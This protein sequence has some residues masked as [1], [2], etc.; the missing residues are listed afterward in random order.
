MPKIKHTL[1]TRSNDLERVKQIAED[2]GVT[3]VTVFRWALTAFFLLY[4]AVKEGEEVTIS[5]ERVRFVF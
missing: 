1:Y 4:V 3:V 5:G 2:E